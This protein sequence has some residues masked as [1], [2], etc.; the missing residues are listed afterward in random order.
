VLSSAYITEHKI[1]KYDNTEE[2]I[3][4][5][6]RYNDAI[7]KLLA[8]NYSGWI[9]FVHNDFSILESIDNIV[10]KLEHTHLYGPIGAILKGSEKIIYGQILQG[11]NGGLIYHGTK[12]NEPTLVDTVDCQCQCLFLHTDLLKKYNLRFDENEALS[13]HQYVEDF[14]LNAN[15]NYGIKTYAVQMN[16]K[17]FSWGKLNND[18]KLAIDYINS[19]YSDKAWAGTCTHVY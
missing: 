14:C 11:H 7:D 15:I 1:L 19:K 2:N 13:F 3:P 5:S 16:C 17:H 6:I 4:I 12:I 9:F 10:D 18:F 8:S